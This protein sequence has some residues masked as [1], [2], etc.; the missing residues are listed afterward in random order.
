VNTTILWC[1]AIRPN[2]A[3]YLE[4][5]FD[6]VGPQVVMIHAWLVQ[7]NKDHSE[8]RLSPR[9]TEHFEIWAEFKDAGSVNRVDGHIARLKAAWGAPEHLVQ[10]QQRDRLP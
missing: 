3:G 10:W 5:H 7:D 4:H 9:G 8:W 1:R 2:F 6:M